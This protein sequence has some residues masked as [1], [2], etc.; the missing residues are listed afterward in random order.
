VGIS[1]AQT[2]TILA[3]FNR[4]VSLAAFKYTRDVRFYDESEIRRTIKNKHMRKSDKIGKEEMP[5]VI[6]KHL[7]D[8]F[9]G[10]LNTK[11]AIATETNDEADGIAAAWCASINWEQR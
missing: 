8:S 1:N 6:R 5:D 7:D 10:P 2:I 11:G 9:Q 4:V 3:G